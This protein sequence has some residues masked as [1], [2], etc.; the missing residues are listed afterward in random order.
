MQPNDLNFGK[1]EVKKVFFP[2]SYDLPNLEQK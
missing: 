1:D 2:K